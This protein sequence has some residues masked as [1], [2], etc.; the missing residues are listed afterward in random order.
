MS[1]NQPPVWSSDARIS[2]PEPPDEDIIIPMYGFG[3]TH[4]R[5]VHDLTRTEYEHLYRP[6]YAPETPPGE[7]SADDLNVHRT[8]TA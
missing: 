3:M 7:V 5:L 1:I 4:F 2:M 6:S 8:G